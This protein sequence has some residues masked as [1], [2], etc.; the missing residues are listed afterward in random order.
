MN[1][2][3]YKHHIINLVLSIL[4]LILDYF[5]TINLTVAILLILLT[6]INSILFIIIF[7]KETYKNVYFSTARFIAEN[8]PSFPVMIF[9]II[10]LFT[11]LFTI[12]F[13][14]LFGS[15]LLSLIVLILL[16]ITD[17]QS[18][19]TRRRIDKQGE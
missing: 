17:I 1:K 2:P 10:P 12:D 6:L 5:N 3:L 11:Y 15:S 4:L 19:L 8:A 14:I 9:L 13:I 18:N 16:L 7:G